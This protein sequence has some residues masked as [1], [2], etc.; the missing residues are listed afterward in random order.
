MVYAVRHRADNIL[1]LERLIHWFGDWIKFINSY[2]S[3]KNYQNNR[4]IRIASTISYLTSFL[5]GEKDVKT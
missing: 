1:S 4:R 3:I 2:Q 5:L